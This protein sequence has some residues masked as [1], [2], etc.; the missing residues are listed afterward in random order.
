MSNIVRTGAWQAVSVGLQRLE[1]NIDK[2]H[3]KIVRKAGQLARRVIVKNLR[4]GGSLVGNPFHP[5]SDVT[6]DLKGSSS[7][8]IDNG[9]LMGSIK[10]KMQGKYRVFV[11]PSRMHPSGAN[12]GAILH[13]GTDRAGRGNSVT[14]EPRRFIGDVAES[15]F[16]ADKIE[17]IMQ[18]MYE[19]MIK[20]L[21]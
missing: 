10:S 3:T 20:E 5:N 21:F 9:D 12:I 13:D 6:I 16:L 14:I 19:Q 2:H 15:N 11:G 7:P 17:N 1:G 18:D 4:S 8:L